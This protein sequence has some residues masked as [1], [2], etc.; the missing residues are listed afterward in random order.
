M[1]TVHP[2]TLFLFRRVAGVGVVWRRCNPRNGASSFV[3][4]NFSLGFPRVSLNIL[5][6]SVLRWVPPAQT[7]VFSV[8]ISCPATSRSSTRGKI[9][10]A[11]EC[12]Q[13]KKS[14]E[15]LDTETVPLEALPPWIGSGP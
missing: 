13:D 3:P 1:L 15:S 12:P 14:E 4:A 6:E 11:G 10:C 8:S 5:E 9:C 7:W 2:P